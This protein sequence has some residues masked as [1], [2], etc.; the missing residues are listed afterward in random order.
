MILAFNFEISE[1]DYYFPNDLLFDL[2]VIIISLNFY[3]HAN[4]KKFNF[5]IVFKYNFEYQN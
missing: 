4:L 5:I 3:S 1:E 2:M